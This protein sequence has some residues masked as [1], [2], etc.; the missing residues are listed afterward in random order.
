MN[1]PKISIIIP[2]YNKVNYIVNTLD[3]ILLQNYPNLELIVQDGGSND[4]TVE[5]VKKYVKKYPKIITMESKKDKGQVDAINK[6]IKKASGEIIGFINADDIYNKRAFFMVVKY[7]L[8]NPKALWFVGSGNIINEKGKEIAH[9]I[10]VYKDALLRINKY[11][12][13]LIVNYIIQPA[14]F[15]SRKAYNRF[16]V[17][18]GTTSFVVEYNSWLKIG[19]VQ[20]PVVIPHQLA[21]FRISLGSISTTQLRDLL[22]NDLKTVRKYTLNPIIL[23]LHLIHNFGRLLLVNVYK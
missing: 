17:F 16:G 1:Y 3:S 6:G 2:S 11:P 15:L 9:P 23:F 8:L 5:I 13:L 21:S 10:K 12:L 18:Q 22:E 20:M 7:F 4:G 14:V 19:K